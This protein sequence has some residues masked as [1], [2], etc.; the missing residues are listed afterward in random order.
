MGKKQ[1]LIGLCYNCFWEVAN[2]LAATPKIS[3][4]LPQVLNL[5]KEVSQRSTQ[6][7]HNYTKTAF[8][9]EKLMIIYPNIPKKRAAFLKQPFS[10]E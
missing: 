2:T 9:T 1:A 4:C 6:L 7:P 3:T 5:S 8:F 10:V